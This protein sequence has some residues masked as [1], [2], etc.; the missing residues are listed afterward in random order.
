MPTAASVAPN[1]PWVP[2]SPPP[3]IPSILHGLLSKMVTWHVGP[4]VRA[5]DGGSLVMGPGPRRV[6]RHALPHRGHQCARAVN[7]LPACGCPVLQRPEAQGL[8]SPEAP[9]AGF[10]VLSARPRH[11][12]RSGRPE[13]NDGGGVFFARCDTW[14]GT[15]GGSSHGSP[16][17]G[18]GSRNS[19]VS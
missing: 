13:G 15:S 5:R 2:G 12:M 6:G 10:R 4:A 16:P 11:C 9:A 18:A 3:R 7:G 19:G 8:H 17:C 14:P 1:A